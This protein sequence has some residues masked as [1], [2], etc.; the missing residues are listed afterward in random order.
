MNSRDQIPNR[1]TEN[2][3]DSKGEGVTTHVFAP[4]R[5]SL[6]GMTKAEKD[7][8]QLQVADY[9]QGMCVDLRAMAHAA[10]LDGLAYFIDMARHEASIQVENRKDKGGSD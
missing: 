6:A 4:H 8:F 2:I 3:N 7:R 10:E 1:K 5:H 9:I